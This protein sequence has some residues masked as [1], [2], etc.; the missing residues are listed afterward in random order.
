MSGKFR[1]LAIDDEP[2]MLKLLETWLSR[3]GFEVVVALDAQTGLHAA[4]HAHPDVILLDVMMPQMDGFDVYRRLRRLTDTP[5]LFVTALD[6]LARLKQA[7]ALGAA[8]YVVKPFRPAELLSRLKACLRRSQ[9]GNG[10]DAGMLFLSDSVILDCNRQ[11]LVVEAREIELTCTEFKVVKLL[12][13]HPGTVFSVNAI[14]TRVWGPDR[15]GDPHLVKHYIYQLRQKIEPDPESPRYLHTV[16]GRG[17]YFQ[18]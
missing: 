3:Q 5:V 17:Y 13:G 18:A 9:P 14:L 16:H 7:F 10:K 1:V 8:D 4:W 12:A 6:D 11:Q 15:M 2:E